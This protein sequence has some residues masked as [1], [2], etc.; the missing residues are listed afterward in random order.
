MSE[1]MDAEGDTFPTSAVDFRIR[2]EKIRGNSGIG[3]EQPG[4]FHKLSRKF[5]DISV[6]AVREEPGFILNSPEFKNK[7]TLCR[8]LRHAVDETPAGRAHEIKGYTVATQVFGRKKDF[9]PAIDPIVRTQAG[10]L[11]RTPESCYPGRGGRKKLRIAIGK[12]SYTPSFFRLIPEKLQ[13]RQSQRRARMLLP[14]VEKSHDSQE[15]S[16]VAAGGGPSINVMRLV[17]LTNDPDQECIA[18][19]LSGEFVVELAG[20][21]GLQVNAHHPVIQWKGKSIGPRQAGQELEA[22]FLPAEAFER[23]GTPSSSPS[24]LSIQTP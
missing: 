4:R 9:D 2:L 6:D 11:R 16:P 7:P 18:V 21:R 23:R 1:V 13:M 12:G 22:G 15:V 20:R 3:A 19:G 14:E 10:R 24:G 17:N 8:F 5:T